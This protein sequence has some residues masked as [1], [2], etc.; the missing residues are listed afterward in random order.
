MLVL[1]VKFLLHGLIVTF[2][3]PD[4]HRLFDRQ[5]EKFAVA[6]LP[7]AG[8]GGDGLEGRFHLRVRDDDFELRRL[9]A[10]H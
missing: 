1:L 3:R 4:P 2:R 6:D 9:K 8:G 10:K 5:D 7:G